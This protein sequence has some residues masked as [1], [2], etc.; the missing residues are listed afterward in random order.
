MVNLTDNLNDIKAALQFKAERFNKDI[1]NA[2]NASGNKEGNS[3][4]VDLLKEEQDKIN[5]LLDKINNLIDE[6]Q[7]NLLLV[8]DDELDIICDQIE[9]M[10]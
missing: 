10:S 3:V 8:G 5:D 9:G 2:I 1:E 4:V 7:Y 6:G